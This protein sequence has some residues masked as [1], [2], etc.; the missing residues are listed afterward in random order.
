MVHAAAGAGIDLIDVP[1]L[2]LDDDAGLE[3]EA[4]R[5]RDLGMTGKGA[6]HPKQLPVIMRTFTPTP[7]EVEEARRIVDA[8]E[9]QDRGLLVV[10]GKL[11][12]KPVVLSMQRVL[13]AAARTPS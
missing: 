7:D 8:F 10:N 11:I 6:I 1:Y 12:E 3:A 9:S 5:A 2:D 13:A 4:Q